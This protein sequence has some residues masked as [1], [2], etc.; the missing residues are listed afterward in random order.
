M[1]SVLT[2]SWRRRALVAGQRPAFPDIR[3]PLAHLRDSSGWQIRQSRL[4]PGSQIEFRID[5]MASAGA[6]DA[7]QGRGRLA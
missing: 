4:A 6:R 3:Q 7:G 5:L 1:R 2:G